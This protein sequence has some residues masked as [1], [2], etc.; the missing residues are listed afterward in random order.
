MIKSKTKFIATN[1]EIERIFVE[2]NMPRIRTV[3]TLGNGEF[4][5]AFKVIYDSLY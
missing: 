5:A 3:E 4:N 1:E 2:N